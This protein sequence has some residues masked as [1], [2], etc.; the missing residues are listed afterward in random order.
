MN[1][2]KCKMYNSILANLRGTKN[3]FPD[4]VVIEEQNAWEFMRNNCKDS[5]KPRT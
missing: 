3:L 4:D 5:F 2:V 1:V